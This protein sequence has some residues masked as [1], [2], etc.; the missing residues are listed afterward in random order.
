MFVNQN[1]V[2]Q[3]CLPMFGRGGDLDWHVGME[4]SGRKQHKPRDRMNIAELEWDNYAHSCTAGKSERMA[5]FVPD[6]W[7]AG[8]PMG[9]H[10]PRYPI[11]QKSFRADAGCGG[12]PYENH[13][14][15][16]VFMRRPYKEVCA[17][18]KEAFRH[19]VAELV[20]GGDQARKEMDRRYDMITHPK[21]PRATNYERPNPGPL[22]KPG[23]LGASIGLKGKMEEMPMPPENLRVPC[24]NPAPLRQSPRKTAAAAEAAA[25][26]VSPAAAGAGSEVALG[27]TST[28]VMANTS[29]RR[30]RQ[31]GSKG[32]PPLRP[33]L[34]GWTDKAAPISPRLDSTN[35][36]SER[37]LAKFGPLPGVPGYCGVTP[38][39]GFRFGPP[40][41]IVDREVTKSKANPVL[42]GLGVPFSD[43]V[44]ISGQGVV[45]D[46]AIFSAP[47][48]IPPVVKKGSAP[49]SVAL[50]LASQKAGSGPP[51]ARS[52]GRAALGSVG[53]APSVAAAEE[54]HTADFLQ[55]LAT[56][57]RSARK[58]PAPQEAQRDQWNTETKEQQQKIRENF[59]KCQAEGRTQ[60]YPTIVEFL[61]AKLEGRIGA[62]LP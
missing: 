57:R 30:R 1:K 55:A 53:T 19:Y 10:D 58:V 41:F 38:G 8:Y 18:D 34:G 59:E 9:Y 15:G 35:A 40:H 62:G 36:I 50:T 11:K 7:R 26:A 32:A 42:V 12:T 4:M 17:S 31:Q 27:E 22:P 29:P 5:M 39:Q 60:R 56:P 49:S 23:T 25:A 28:T 13:R 45:Q 46:G 47:A 14:R 6:H 44:A 3:E 61:E 16:Y 48:E 24:P 54:A 52:D 51:G 37:L 2:P 33:V 43:G 21:V 20:E